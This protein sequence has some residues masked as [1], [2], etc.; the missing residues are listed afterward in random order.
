VG[1]QDLVE[2]LV[3]EQ[4]FLLLVLAVISCFILAAAGV[5]QL[6]H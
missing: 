5:Q 2:E 3:A 1:L 6:A 4:G